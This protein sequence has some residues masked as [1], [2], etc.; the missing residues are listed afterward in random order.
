MC[1]E[2]GDDNLAE[3]DDDPAEFLV[4]EEVHVRKL[5]FPRWVERE[6]ALAPLLV[7]N[8]SQMDA[9]LISGQAERAA[10]RLRVEA[11]LSLRFWF[12]L[13][14]SEGLRTLCVLVEIA[15]LPSPC[16]LPEARISSAS[17]RDRS[18]FDLYCW[19]FLRCFGDGGSI[20]PLIILLG[21]SRGE[22]LPLVLVAVVAV[23]VVAVAVLLLLCK[24]HDMTSKDQRKNQSVGY[25]SILACT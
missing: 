2:D 18:Q 23:A 16:L 10:E 17:E 19:A 15:L 20:F 9:L 4:V 24:L 3:V 6:E 12:L 7:V 25:C 1:E 22:W 14:I 21:I 5:L 8:G 13:E 11:E